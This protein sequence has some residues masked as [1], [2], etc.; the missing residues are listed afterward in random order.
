MPSADMYFLN[1]D[2]MSL[3]AR[4]VPGKGFLFEKAFGEG[5]E[6]AAEGVGI[7]AEIGVDHG[8]GSTHL[9]LR[10]VGSEVVGGVTVEA[11]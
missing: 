10:G 4:P 3:V 6:K 11:A 1:L 9:R 5:N 2:E 7:Y 8:I